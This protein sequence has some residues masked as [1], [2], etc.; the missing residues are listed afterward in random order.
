M[1]TYIFGHTT[2]DSD[3]IIGAIALS[4][5]RNRLGYES[6]PSRQGEINPESRFILER[7]GLEEPILK[8]SYSGEDVY[9]IDLWSV[10]KPLR[11]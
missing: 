2:P 11:Y 4:Y 6:I 5:L 9:L 3:S 1:A 8:S 7:F 10:P